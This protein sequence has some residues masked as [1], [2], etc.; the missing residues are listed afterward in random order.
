L[1]PPTGAEWLAPSD[2]RQ[3]RRCCRQA[4][5]APLPRAC[6]TGHP[7]QTRAKTR[8]LLAAWRHADVNFAETPTR[9]AAYECLPFKSGLRTLIL[10]YFPALLLNEGQFVKIFEYIKKLLPPISPV[11]SFFDL[12]HA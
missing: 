3:R 11:I 9:S 10:S 7:T 2:A 12:F 5:F 1:L 4:R 6:Q 8:R